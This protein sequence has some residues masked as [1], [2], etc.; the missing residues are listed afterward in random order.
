LETRRS[1]NAELSRKQR[2]L[3]ILD[4]D[5]TLVHA[6]E[7]PLERQPDFESGPYHVYVRPG[8]E[9]FLTACNELFEL[10]VWT[11]ATAPYAGQVV[12]RAFPPNIHL[13][14]LWARER[15]TLRV[16][17]ETR[18]E[19]WLKDLSKVKRKGYDLDHVLVV[20]DSPEKLARNYGNLVAIAPYL[21]SPHD[22]ELDRLGDYLRG[23]AFTD[24]VRAIEKR[25]WRKENGAAS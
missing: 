15:C 17:P 5:E 1:V 11:S 13:S 24:N 12:S 23:L 21:G 8:L 3:L 2:H 4:I 19:F 7:T 20:D 6:A 9:S 14:F 18:E 22:A 10:A 25:Y 16:H